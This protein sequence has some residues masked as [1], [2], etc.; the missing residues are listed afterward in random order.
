MVLAGE[1]G[2]VPKDGEAAAAAK[3][4]LGAAPPSTEHTWMTLDD[5]DDEDGDDNPLPE[6]ADAEDWNVKEGFARLCAENNVPA[7]LQASFLFLIRAALGAHQS[8]AW[9]GSGAIA[10]AGRSQRMR[11]TLS[12]VDISYCEENTRSDDDV[13]AAKLRTVRDSITAAISTAVGTIPGAS[14]TVATSE[15]FIPT[16]A[17]STDTGTYFLGT[18]G[19]GGYCNITVTFPSEE[20]GGGGATTIV[21]QLSER[22]RAWRPA[23]LVATYWGSFMRVTVT[24]AGLVGRCQPAAA[25]ATV[26]PLSV[27]LPCAGA[28]WKRTT[29]GQPRPVAHLS[30]LHAAQVIDDFFTALEIMLAPAAD[31]TQLYPHVYS[32]HAV[33]LPEWSAHPQEHTAAMK[34]WSEKKDTQECALIRRM[35]T[36]HGVKNSGHTSRG[37][38]SLGFAANALRKNVWRFLR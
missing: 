7:A 19:S 12:D 30:A 13:A 23:Q 9:T 29:A 6:P 15:R 4:L 24:G 27:L 33:W 20:G 2:A 38:N 37:E 28:A 8:A 14:C 5:D 34:A 35:G 32:K 3:A 10:A 16:T 22:D 11:G 1:G 18:C 36:L 31:P 21:F 25:S 26:N 17:P